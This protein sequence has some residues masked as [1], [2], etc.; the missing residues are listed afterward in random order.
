IDQVNFFGFGNQS[1]RD[2][3]LANS[4]FYQVT[5]KRLVVHPQL[6]VAVAGPLHALVGGMFE[7]VNGT[8]RVPLSGQFPQFHDGTLMAVE[9][10]FDFDTSRAA[11]VL[12]RGFK[13]TV[14]G[15]YYPRV[16]SLKSDF[17]KMRGSAA[18]FVPFHLLTDFLFSARVAGEKNWGGYPWFESAFLVRV[19]CFF[20]LE[21]RTLMSHS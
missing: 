18:Y 15:R 17:A 13:A 9:A 8:E 21:S 7:Y 11:G 10:G 5:Q 20:V 16:L 2:E 1:L 4:D 19:S 12:Q 14:I 3:A 6:D